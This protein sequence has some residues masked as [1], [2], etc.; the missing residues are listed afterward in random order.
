MFRP[1]D[2]APDLARAQ[3]GG[4]HHAGP[5]AGDDREAGAT[6]PGG[7]LARE[8]VL[9]MA[10]RRARRAEDRHAPPHLLQRAKAVRE[11]V[12]DALQPVRLGALRGDRRQLR[13]EQLLVGCRG[14]P[15]LGHGARPYRRRMVCGGGGQCEGMADETSKPPDREATAEAAPAESVPAAE[16]PAAD[17][18]PE[19]PA[20]EPTAAGAPPEPPPAAA[21]EPPHA[22]PAAAAAPEPPAAEPTAATPEP[23]PP[24]HRN[25]R[26]PPSTPHPRR[27]RRRRL[28]PRPAQRTRRLPPA[29]RLRRVLLPL[30]G[31]MRSPSGGGGVVGDGA[32]SGPMGVRP[33][34]GRTRRSPA[35]SRAAT[36]RPALSRAARSRAASARVASGV[37]RASRDGRGRRGS[38]GR[39][40]RC[41]SR[42][43]AP[44]RRV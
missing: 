1:T 37:R 9:G 17:P 27:L 23:P 19:P 36:R 25:R 2:V 20:A 44:R 24:P 31:L 8:L 39:R 42:S 18:A 12:V 30:R 34:K 43:C 28:P 11:L 41:R 14:R 4:L 5:A 16:P 7:D 6:E 32:R 29:T 22:E 3:V 21:P 26:L 40:G 13:V 15:G 33:P 35:R 38:R 10:G